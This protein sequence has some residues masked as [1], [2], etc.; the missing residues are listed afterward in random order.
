MNIFSSPIGRLAFLGRYI[1]ALVL[2]GVG[3]ASLS[4]VV[5]SQNAMLVPFLMPLV[6]VFGLLGLVYMVGFAL[7]PRLVSVG[8]SKWFALLLFVPPVSL[9]FVLFLLFC[10][11]GRFSRHDKVA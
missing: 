5:E 1:L 7:F 9:P 8:L 10:P 11:A 3:G 6:L 4:I 2:L